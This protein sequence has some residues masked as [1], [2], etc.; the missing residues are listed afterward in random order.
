MLDGSHYM[1]D[2][3]FEAKV[4]HD[5]SFVKNSKSKSAKIK[6]FAFHMIFDTSSGSNKDVDTT[7]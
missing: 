7:T 3:F 1:F 6:V 4:K 5:V 2:I